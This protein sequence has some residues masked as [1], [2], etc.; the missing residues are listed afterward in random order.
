[1]EGNRKV[2]R[3]IK[4][5]IWTSS[6]PSGYRVNP[7]RGTQFRIWATNILKL[8]SRKWLHY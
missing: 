4:F 5:I 2:E 7:N 8:A 6:F 1:M 3:K